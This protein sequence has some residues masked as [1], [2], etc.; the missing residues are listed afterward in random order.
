MP[1]SYSSGESS[2]LS[3]GLQTYCVHMV[4][5]ARE[6]SWA[7]SLRVLILFM[8]TLPSRSNHLPKAP[9]TKVITL[10]N[11]IP[12]CEFERRT[13]NIQTIA[14]FSFWVWNQERLL[15]A[16]KYR[17]EDGG[18]EWKEQYLHWRAHDQCFMASFLNM[19]GWSRN[20]IY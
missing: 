9:L 11:K 20:S 2:L 15:W 8:R 13:M 18:V 19:N 5:E 7:S 4:E 14:L 12:L 3:C 17:L 16:N 10:G 6:L 1:A